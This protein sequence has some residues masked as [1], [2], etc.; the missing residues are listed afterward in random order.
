MPFRG[1]LFA[2]SFFA[3]SP[4]RLYLLLRFLIIETEEKTDSS[5]EFVLDVS[6]QTTRE[7]QAK[8]LPA[9]WEYLAV[10]YSTTGP[11]STKRYDEVRESHSSSVVFLGELQR[12]GGVNN[13]F[14][15]VAKWWRRF[16][17]ACEVCRTNSSHD[18]L[19]YPHTFWSVLFSESF[20][21]KDTVS[22][23]VIQ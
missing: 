2:H 15:V 1:S 9:E 6:V 4:I 8:H 3:T 7:P 16:E 5:R 13:F 12:G 10:F 14:V 22:N 21:Y 20:S 18:H 17:V 11:E 23:L 19:R